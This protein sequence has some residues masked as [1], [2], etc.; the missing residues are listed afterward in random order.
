MF[1][2]LPAA[3]SACTP[4]SRPDPIELRPSHFKSPSFVVIRSSVV[5]SLFIMS[6]HNFI[7][8]FKNAVVVP[9]RR[10]SSTF[11][12]QI[13]LPAH[14]EEL[15]K[16]TAIVEARYP[17]FGMIAH[18]LTGYQPETFPLVDPQEEEH[19]HLQALYDAAHDPQLLDV[20][21]SIMLPP[22]TF[23]IQ[24]VHFTDPMDLVRFSKAVH[25]GP[26]IQYGQPQ[27]AA[28]TEPLTLAIKT[29][30][31]VGLQGFTA[32]KNIGS[33]ASGVVYLVR[34]DHTQKLFAL[35]RIDKKFLSTEGMGL[36]VQEQRMLRTMQGYRNVISLEASFHDKNSFF[37]AMPFHVGGDMRTELHRSAKFQAP[38]VT[39]YAAQILSALEFIHSKGIIHRD[40]KPENLLFDAE[41][42]VQVC[43]FGIS[44]QFETTRGDIQHE[45]NPFCAAL[46]R[47]RRFSASSV[48]TCPKRFTTSSC[49]GTPVYSPP[50]VFR[51]DSYS[52]EVDFWSFG[53]TVY[54]MATGRK[55]FKLSAVLNEVYVSI[56]DDQVLFK[57]ADNVDR[58][59]QVF[60]IQILQTDPQFR[61]SLQEMKEHCF[62]ETI[63]WAKLARGEI[64]PPWAPDAARIL[65]E[66]AEA[67]QSNYCFKFPVAEAVV[68]DPFPLYTF[69]SERFSAASSAALASVQCSAP[70]SA[71]KS[72]ADSSAPAH[73]LSGSALHRLSGYLS[74]LRDFAASFA[75]A[76]PSLSSSFRRRRCSTVSSDATL[77]STSSHGTLYSPSPAP[78]SPS[79]SC[80]SLGSE[81]ISIGEVFVLQ[82][83]SATPPSRNPF[84]GLRRWAQ[85]L[86]A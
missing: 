41:G 74:E 50:E 51:G 4:A 62:F 69:R 19:E 78:S 83:P 3:R 73:H 12:N 24:E 7:A 42:N 86:R 5:I 65:S 59:T 39:F 29:P 36:V 23:D 28:A 61:L 79:E 14:G 8:S 2:I 16:V 45:T 57:F 15:S 20:R 52:Y 9:A 85:K 17:A 43:D 27:P 25:T 10:A 54:E 56:M 46:A 22:C 21:R 82:P 31:K 75:V 26:I 33:G 76:S 13:A 48:E 47:A 63:D 35:K 34:L 58:W 60:V 38:R 6:L 40:I 49:R 70:A 64:T 30:P 81:S 66:V 37:L 71:D 53:V 18:P 55:P 32:I 84:A 44:K 72:S 80:S 11:G 1:Q 68:P 67:E 77:I